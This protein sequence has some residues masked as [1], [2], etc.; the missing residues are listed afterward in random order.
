[1]VP[2]ARSLSPTS[3]SSTAQ[4]A[5]E[6]LQWFGQAFFEQALGVAA[7]SDSEEYASARRRCLD[8]GRHGIDAAARRASSSM[9]SSTPSYAPAIP[10]DLVNPES[11]FGS[12]TQP[13]AMAGYPLLTVPVAL[14]LGLPV[15]VSFW[16]DGRQRDDPDRDRGRLSRPRATPALGPLPAPTFPAFV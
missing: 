9:R 4:R 2:T 15:A 12:C 3:W 14:A 13:T 8:H 16:G 10:I 6:E 7:G 5:D 11:D 1:M